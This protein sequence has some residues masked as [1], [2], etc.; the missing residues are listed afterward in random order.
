M[1][2]EKTLENLEIAALVV[3][4]IIFVGILWQ[5]CTAS[6]SMKMQNDHFDIENRPYLYLVLKNPGINRNEDYYAGGEFELR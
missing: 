2:K 6:S 4:V 3:Q 5:A 1:N